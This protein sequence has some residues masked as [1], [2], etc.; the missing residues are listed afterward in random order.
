M[1]LSCRFKYKLK[2][3]IN[4]EGRF[5]FLNPWQQRTTSSRAESAPA[6]CAVF[7]PRRAEKPIRSHRVENRIRRLC[8]EG[9]E[10]TGFN[11]NLYLGAPKTPAII[12]KRAPEATDTGYSRADLAPGSP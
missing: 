10:Q 9:V 5:N 1:N 6:I 3:A 2:R 4:H 11:R 12:R 8:F 7:Q